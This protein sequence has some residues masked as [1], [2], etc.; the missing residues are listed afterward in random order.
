MEQEGQLCGHLEDRTGWAGGQ[1]LSSKMLGLQPGPGSLPSRPRVASGA[2]VLG[3]SSASSLPARQLPPHCPV[4]GRAA[5]G[6]CH[7]RITEPGW[8]QGGRQSCHSLVRSPFSPSSCS[9]YPTDAAAGEWASAWGGRGGR[10]TGRG[11]HPPALR[12]SAPRTPL[13]PQSS[14]GVSGRFTG[15]GTGPAG[16]HPREQQLSLPAPSQPGEQVARPPLPPPDTQDSTQCLPGCL[17]AALSGQR[18]RPSWRLE[19]ALGGG[20]GSFLPDPRACRA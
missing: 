9:A 12:A 11:C 10:T 18:S 6:S 19:W 17:N 7:F 2:S 3:S 8:V 16:T 5:G 15:K 14:P 20:G 1:P 4:R 13:R